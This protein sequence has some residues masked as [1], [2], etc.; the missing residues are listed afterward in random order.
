MHTPN[1][2][3]SS[4]PDLRARKGLGKGLL[5]AVGLV[6]VGGLVLALVFFRDADHNPGRDACDHIEALAAKDEERWSK[7]VEALA[8][9]VEVRVYDQGNKRRIEIAEGPRYE[10]CRESFD[11]IRESM[12]YGSY[13]ALA[14]CVSKMTTWRQ[15]SSCFS[16]F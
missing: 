6:L 4:V 13:T 8:R 1:V 16:T 9:T 5:I 14:E 2:A 15:G 7:F 12:S 11:V 10:R 3:S